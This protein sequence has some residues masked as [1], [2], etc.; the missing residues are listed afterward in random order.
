MKLGFNIVNLI[1][2]GEPN[3]LTITGSNGNWDIRQHPNYTSNRQ[4]LNS[5]VHAAVTYIADHDDLGLSKEEEILEELNQLCLSFSYLTSNAVTMNQSA[6][7][8][9]I[10]FIQVG[11]GFPRARGITGIEPIVNNQNDLVTASSQMLLRF[12]QNKIDYHIDVIIQYWLDLLSCWSLENLFLGACTILEIIKQCERRRTGIANLHFFDAIVSVST[13]LGITVLNRDWISMRNDLIHEG[14]LS[15][16]R[17]PNK[18]KFECIEVCEGVMHWI[19]EFTHS[20][21]N[22]GTI[23]HDRFNR[24][25]LGQLNSYTTWT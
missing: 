23:K 11:D 8:S 13:H 25:S 6:V 4:A 17:F 21:F 14:H 2:Q 1:A 16:V 5:L 19:D 18:T 22:L 24:G 20:I 9:R 3:I 12:N 10:S 7:Y 15:K